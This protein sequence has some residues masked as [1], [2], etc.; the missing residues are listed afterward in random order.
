VQALIEEQVLLEFQ[1]YLVKVHNLEEQEQD[2]DEEE[3]EVMYDGAL[4]K[5]DSAISQNH[6]SASKLHRF[7]KTT[8]ILKNTDEGLLRADQDTQ[9]P[10][11]APSH[12]NK[13]YR[14]SNPTLT[15]RKNNQRNTHLR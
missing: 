9:S 12:R 1:Q 11:T 15:A 10:S 14:P 5:E 7:P 6:T 2:Q 4:Y 3:E 13:G 8:R